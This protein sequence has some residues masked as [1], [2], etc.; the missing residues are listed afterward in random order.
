MLKEASQENL[1]INAQQKYKEDKRWERRKRSLSGTEAEPKWTF[2]RVYTIFHS[3]DW[4]GASPCIVTFITY[5][6]GNVGIL[7]SGTDKCIVVTQMFESDSG[8]SKLGD[9]VYPSLL[10]PPTVVTMVEKLEREIL[11]IVPWAHGEKKAGNKS[12]QIVFL[13]H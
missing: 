1:K 5:I 10:V 2:W 4:S 7:L 6:K 13:K 11:C 9:F 12:F 8:R 3:W